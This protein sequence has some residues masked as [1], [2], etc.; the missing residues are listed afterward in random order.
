MPV[1]VITVLMIQ[2]NDIRCEALPANKE[3]TLW[4]GQA[5]LFKGED[6]HTTVL[7]TAPKYSSAEEALSVITA[8]VDQI[9]AIDIKQMKIA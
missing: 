5:N 6:L 4:F 8:I 9:R 1:L 3:G 2:G 7:S